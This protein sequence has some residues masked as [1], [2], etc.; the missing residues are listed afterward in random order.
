MHYNSHT[1]IKKYILVVLILALLNTSCNTFSRSTTDPITRYKNWINDR[2]FIFTQY[3]KFDNVY[4]DNCQFYYSQIDNTPFSDAYLSTELLSEMYKTDSQ[5]ISIHRILSADYATYLLNLI[6]TKR[7]P[8]TISLSDMN[9]ANVESVTLWLDGEIFVL[10]YFADNTY[11]T[12]SNDTWK[13]ASTTTLLKLDVAL[14]N[15][16]I[17][18]KDISIKI[19]INNTS[20]IIDIPIKSMMKLQEYREYLSEDVLH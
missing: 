17:E 20:Q 10:P 13:F 16:I 8:N 1:S 7:Y 4:E 5:T 2:S 19:K 9:Y 12:A 11:A 3:D 15:H 14:F 6:Y 18:S